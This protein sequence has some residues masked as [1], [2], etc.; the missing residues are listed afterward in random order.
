[1]QAVRDFADHN[2]QVEDKWPEGHEA[3]G[4]NKDGAFLV[5]LDGMCLLAAVKI[6]GLPA[7]APFVWEGTGTK[8]SSALLSA[9]SLRHTAHV[10]VVGSEARRVHGI[11]WPD[12]ANV[13]KTPASTS[14]QTLPTLPEHESI[15]I[16]RS[17]PPSTI[18]E[19]GSGM[20]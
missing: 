6:T 15:E 18:D 20:D 1:M 13:S 10:V 17:E 16:F 3:A 9:W 4:L 11:I 5:D 2:Q 8:H 14:S 19:S 12:A 7:D